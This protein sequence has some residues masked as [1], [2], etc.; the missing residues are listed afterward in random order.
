MHLNYQ[1]FQMMF[2]VLFIFFYKY[3][4]ILDLT[5][6]KLTLKQ[7]YCDYVELNLND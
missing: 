7:I 3:F 2:V 1:S 5:C 6:N 4:Q